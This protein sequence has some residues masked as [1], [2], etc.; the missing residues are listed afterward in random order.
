MEYVENGRELVQVLVDRLFNMPSTV[1]K[2]GRLVKLP[3]PTLQL[4]REKPVQSN[5][6]WELFFVL[7]RDAV[8]DWVGGDL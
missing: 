3:K 6:D 1:D 2:A 7:G 8:W 4:P 5:F